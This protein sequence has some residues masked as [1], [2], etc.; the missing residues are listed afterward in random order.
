MASELKK[1]MPEKVG[2]IGLGVMGRNLAKNLAGKDLL[3]VA[4]DRDRRLAHSLSAEL[5]QDSFV[6]ASSV[7]ELT[8]FLESPRTIL[9]MVPAGRAVDELIE[10]LTPLLNPGDVLVDGGNSHYADTERR[11]DLLRKRGI[12]FVGMGVSGGMKGALTGPSLMP[13]GDRE[14]YEFLE[15]VLQR[16][17]ARSQYGPSVAYM[18]R[19]SAGHFVK[20][21]H[22]GIEYALIESLAEAYDALRHVHGLT[23][24]EIGEVFASWRDEPFGGYLLSASAHVLKLV[25]PRTGGPL[26]D[27]V[28]DVAGQKGTGVWATQTAVEHE[29]P[30]FSVSS[31]LLARFAS[32][33]KERRVA[34]ANSARGQLEFPRRTFTERLGPDAVKATLRFAFTVSFFEGLLMLETFSEKFDYGT[35]LLDVLKVWR[36]GSIVES[37]VI[38]TFVM[39]LSNSSTHRVHEFLTCRGILELLA[40]N[41]EEAL[42]FSRIAKAHGVPTTTIDAG[43]NFFLSITRP[44]LPASFIQLVRDHFGHHGFEMH[45]AT[46]IFHIDTL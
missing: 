3:V 44:V 30:A 37:N 34:I 25:D 27:F 17:A 36:A 14:T 23:P 8:G 46:G 15:P 32:T 41:F 4:F 24:P 43:L 38:D 12:Y 11:Y 22:N 35:N 31:A 40:Q 13:G 39:C 7:A 2:L 42:E 28:V 16:I 9:L 1:A 20:M 18:G 19:R 45:N 6:A 29:F 5:P 26:V 21:V 33:Q 10:E